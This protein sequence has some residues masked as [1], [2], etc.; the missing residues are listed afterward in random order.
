MTHVSKRGAKAAIVFAPARRALVPRAVAASA[1]SL[2]NVA[3][4]DMAARFIDPPGGA[5]NASYS[6]VA[7]V[8]AGTVVHV[9]GQVAL[10][11][12]GQL[13]GGS[14][15]AAQTARVYD[16]LRACL[17]AAGCGFADVFKVTTYVVDLTPG[18][19]DIVRAVRA[20]FLPAG[21]RPASTMVGVT[22]LVRPDLLV[23]VEAMA[24]VPGSADGT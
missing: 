19:A 21:H 20:R 11:E 8:P 6:H 14:D 13:V 24:L 10:D 5:P 1:L 12:D 16:N 22:G 17:A 4:E 7:A 9:S 18:N 2:T 3:K 15:L 23:E